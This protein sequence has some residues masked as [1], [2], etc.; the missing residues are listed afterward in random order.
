MAE[1][2]GEGE[3]WERRPYDELVLL[4]LTSEIFRAAIGSYESVYRY[5]SDHLRLYRDP[6]ETVRR[7]IADHFRYADFPVLISAL[8]RTLFTDSY[9]YRDPQVPSHGSRSRAPVTEF[10]FAQLDT[11]S[12]P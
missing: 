4:I 8:V 12:E 9:R 11:Q 7:G 1:P 6:E 2:S 10:L 5:L 3:R